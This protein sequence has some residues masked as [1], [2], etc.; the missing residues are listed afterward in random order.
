MVILQNLQHNISKA[1]FIVNKENLIHASKENTSIF[2]KPTTIT[3][4]IK[5]FRV[6]VLFTTCINDKK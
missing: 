3:K 6:S 4:K 2:F 5:W 1:D